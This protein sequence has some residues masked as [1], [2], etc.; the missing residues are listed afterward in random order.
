MFII[1]ENTKKL[2]ILE[3]NISEYGKAIE[4]ARKELIKCES[5][6]ESAS[7]TIEEMK[8]AINLK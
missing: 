8:K 2:E 4:L 3:K 7:K 6:F 1:M 5:V